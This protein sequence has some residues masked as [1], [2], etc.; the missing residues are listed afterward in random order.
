MTTQP[1]TTSATYTAGRPW[2]ASTHGTDQTETVTVDA[3]KLVATTHYVAS[4]DSTQP[5]SRLLSGLPLGKIT[6]S[7]LYGPY[8]PAATDG[9]Q[10]FVG[11]VFDEALFAPGQPKIPCALL[12]HGVARA[13]K[14]PGGIDTT[15]ITASPGGALIRWV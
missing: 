6:A 10:A 4:T 9:R 7:G 13:S 3:S 2:L 1:I 14:I 11:L 8:D 15:K 12:W 5:Y